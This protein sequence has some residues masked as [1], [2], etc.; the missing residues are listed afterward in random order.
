MSLSQALNAPLR[1]SCFCGTISYAL[2]AKPVLSAYC[3][4]T[5]CQR[6]TGCPFVHTLHFAAV[7]FSWTFPE[8]HDAQLDF[9]R[10][11][12][13][14]HKTRCRCKTCGATVASYNTDTNCWSVWGAHLQRD[15]NGRI[16]DWDLVQPTAHIFYATSML[17]IND[18]LGKW[19]G[20][21][22]RS[23]RLS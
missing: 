17:N 23:A 6:L 4:C 14:P 12:N 1:G 19:E 21:E 9:Y 2:S 13:K 3:H 15:I 11:P 10:I 5:N 20:Y 7:H 22:N 16:E 18:G 8:P